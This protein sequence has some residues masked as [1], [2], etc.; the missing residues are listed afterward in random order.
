MTEEFK[1][2]EKLLKSGEIN[3]DDINLTFLINILSNG[4]I[5]KLNNKAQTLG[6]THTQCRILHYIN[7]MKN[8]GKEVCLYDIEK[9][10]C[11]KKPTVSGIIKRLEAKE[12]IEVICKKEDKRCK[13][14]IV[15]SKAD[16]I[17]KESKINADEIEKMLMKNIKEE[18]RKKF[19]EILLVM[20]K[21]IIEEE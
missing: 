8:S 4:L 16:E 6:V 11:L 18:E 14:V 9:H 7:N 13:K 2:L 3:L 17:L 20:L 19:A 1:A 21:N 5:T 15:T 10:F 12:L